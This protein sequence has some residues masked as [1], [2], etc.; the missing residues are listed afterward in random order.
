MYSTSTEFQTAVNAYARKM[1]G[2]VTIN[3]TDVFLDPTIEA[4]STDENYISQID[5]LVNGRVDMTY[6]YFELDGIAILD[7]GFTCLPD[8][9]T[10]AAFNEMGWWSASRSSAT[11]IINTT[12]TVTFFSRSVSSFL[13]VGDNMRN[14]Y[15][16]DFTVKF[17]QDTTLLYTETVTGN[18]TVSTQVTFT[19]LENV[20]SAVLNITKWSAFLTPVKIAEF[21]TQVIEIYNLEE[22]CSFDITEEREISNDNSIPVGNISASEASICLENIGRKFD[23]NNSYSRLYGSVKPNAL[24]DIE[25]G[26]ETSTGIEYIPLFKG[27]VTEWDV[28]EDSKQASTT[29]QDRL[30]LLTQTYI[31]TSTVQEGLTFFDWFE[32]VLQ[33]AGL[34]NTEYNID[35]TL[36]GTDYIIPYGWLS[37][38]THRS[39]LETIAQG[40]SATV[41]VDRDGLIQVKPINSFSGTSVETF[42]RSDYSSKSNQP[43]Y[44]GVYNSVTV[45]TSPLV[46]TTDTTV[47]ESGSTDPETATASKDTTVTIY[48]T[49]EPVDDHVV[50]I[51]PAVSGVS[52][53]SQSNYSWGSTIKVTNTNVVD[54][55]FQLLVVGSIYEVSG[56]KTVN[57]TD[58]DSINDNGTIEFEYPDNDFLQSKTLAKAIADD[59]VASFKD[60]QR[61]LT[62][63]F[64][65]G[66]N[67]SIELGD[68]I[69]ITDAYTSKDYKIISTDISYDGGLGITHTGRA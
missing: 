54:T 50:S 66:G 15:P 56:Q 14:E 48:Y 21:T 62:L 69:T 60:P 26:V 45:T 67:P 3:Y 64:D 38:V 12:S 28:P 40:C 32:L 24:V 16:V 43:V 42:T 57:S 1:Y 51:S 18:T 55:D 44:G 30:N 49:D 53:T 31:T 46:K 65:V 5:Q 59:L 11:G 22:L 4:T 68:T 8:T 25:I 34:A 52:I 2:K 35:T 41:W 39:A 33:D 17:Y 9:D 13:V 61:D 10:S 19:Q 7:N 27:W 63:G 47:Y 58:E 20:T 23:A 37:N 36:D 6:K 29:A